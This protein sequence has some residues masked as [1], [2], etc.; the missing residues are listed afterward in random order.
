MPHVKLTTN[1]LQGQIAIGGVDMSRVVTGVSL[2][3]AA[4]RLPQLSLTLAAINGQEFEL[5]DAEVSIDGVTLPLEVEVA[6]YRY[7]VEKHGPVEMKA[8][9]IDSLRVQHCARI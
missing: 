6:L 4:G 1:G 8:A 2:D 9:A 3:L 7:L 5:S